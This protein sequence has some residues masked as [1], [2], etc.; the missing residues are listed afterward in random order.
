MASGTNFFAGT[1]GGGVFLSTDN[2][3]GWGEVNSGLSD[4]YVSF[5]AVSGLNLFAITEGGSTFLSAN[6]GKNWEA[7]RGFSDT[8][9]C[10][11]AV[12][13]TNLFAGTES[14]CVWRLPL[15]KLSIEQR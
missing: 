15:S 10:C 11:L 14:G 3:E 5:P 4:T 2:G 9:V 1:E 13:G 12:S 8:H 6:N 7:V